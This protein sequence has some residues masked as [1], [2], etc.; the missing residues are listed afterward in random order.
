MWPNSSSITFSL[1]MA[2]ASDIEAIGLML[3]DKDRHNLSIRDEK[4]QV[5][6]WENLKHTIGMGSFSHR[7]NSTDTQQQPITWEY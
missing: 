6:T 2:S 1:E 5:H 7:Q 3:D 4:Y